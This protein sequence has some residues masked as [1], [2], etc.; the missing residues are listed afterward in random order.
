M[1]HRG[2]D[3][4]AYASVKPS[5]PT[6][7]EW[8]EG[9][10]LFCQVEHNGPLLREVSLPRWAKTAVGQPCSIPEGARSHAMVLRTSSSGRPK[11]GTVCR[12]SAPRRWRRKSADIRPPCTCPRRGGDI[13]LIARWLGHES[14]ETTHC[15]RDKR[16][17]I[18]HGRN[19]SPEYTLQ[20]R[21]L[22]NLSTRPLLFLPNHTML[23]FD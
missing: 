11:A 1:P 18:R 20:V 22:S 14:I 12:T 8:E 21:E 5:I 2:S 23:L 6:S 13:A 15:P 7:Q 9:L 3:C 17:D 16:V 4:G 19:T 10:V